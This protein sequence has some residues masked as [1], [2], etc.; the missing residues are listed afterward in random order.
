MCGGTFK[1]WDLPLAKAIWLVNTRGSTNQAGPA[2]SESLCT[3]DIDKVPVVH[4]RGM[5][6]KTVCINPTSSKGKLICG[7][8]FSQGPGYT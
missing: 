4:M 3:E 6:G 1:H 7:I 5:L 2:H 8:V